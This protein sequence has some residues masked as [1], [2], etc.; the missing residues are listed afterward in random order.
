MVDYIY[1]NLY[2]LTDEQVTDA[3]NG[4]R[5]TTFTYNA[6]GNR[7]TQDS[8][9]TITT[10]VY[11]DNDRSST[12]TAGGVT[13]TY[14]YDDNGNTLSKS[15]GTTTVTYTYDDENRLL[16]ENDGTATNY[17]YDVRKIRDTDKLIS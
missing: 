2:R 1:D 15:D 7:L 14:A 9:G 12:E 6:V 8:D 3:T 4:N 11:D 10:Y 13:T 17:Q 16:S 5:N